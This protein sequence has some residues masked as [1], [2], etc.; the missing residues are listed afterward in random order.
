MKFAILA[1]AAGAAL[2]TGCDTNMLMSLDPFVTP[3]QAVFEPGLV[4]VWAN[5]NAGD[6]DL[7]IIRQSG[8]AGYKITYVGGKDANLVLDALLFRAG[9]TTV[10]DLTQSDTGDFAIAAHIPVRVW[11]E[12]NQF[13]WAYLDSEW[14]RQKASQQLPSR[15]VEKR[16][17]L[18]APGNA[19]RGFLMKYA[20][21]EQAHSEI[22]TW[23]RL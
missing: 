13:R 17:L 21:E 12:G 4:G 2:M 10:M 23:S 5:G 8:D 7:C 9:D 18:A 1:V 22:M 19:T 15:L 6:S 3:E 11:I 20:G 14:L 16:T